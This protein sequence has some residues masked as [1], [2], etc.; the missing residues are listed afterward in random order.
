[1][2]S[3]AIAGLV[4]A[5]TK[6]DDL[7]A[8]ADTLVGFIADALTKGGLRAADAREVGELMIATDLLGGDGHGIFRLP[9]YLARLKAGGFNAAPNIRVEKRKGG[10]ALL[11][12]DNAMGHLVMKRAAELAT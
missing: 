7:K 5:M 9:R 6:K 10:M 4:I 2:F 1:M 12:G 8:P 3:H 11:D